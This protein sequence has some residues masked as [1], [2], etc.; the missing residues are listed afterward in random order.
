MVAAALL[1]VGVSKAPQ[2]KAANLYWD[3]D[4]TAAG[5]NISN[6]TGLGGAGTWDTSELEWF[7]G[8]DNVAWS[9]SALDVAYF[10]GTAGTVTLG[11]PITVGGLVFTG[12]DYTLTGG[13]L[14]LAAATG[15]PEIAVTNGNVATLASV[16]AGTSGL[17]KTGEGTLRL[18]QAAN[19]YAGTTTI[20]GGLLIISDASQ[21]GTDASAIVVTA[22][23]NTPSNTALIGFAGG[24][25]VLDGLGAS[26]DLARPLNLE[27]RGPI[28]N[29]GAALFS[30]GNNTL[31]GL[32]TASVSSQ[33]PATFR[34]TRLTSSNGVLTLSGGLVVQGT[35]GTTFT[36]LGG[37]NQGGVANY[38]LTG[39]LTGTGTLQKTGGGTLNLSPSD[40]SGF[41]GRVR[42]SGSAANGQSS[43][44]VTSAAAFGTANGGTT[45]ATIDIDG[46]TLEA[47]TDTTINFAKNVY[48]RA[49][50]RFFV[51]NAI[52]G[53][54]VN[55]GVA[56]GNFSFEDNQ[57][58]TFASRNGFGA[59]FTTAPVNGGDANNTFNNDQAGLLAFSGNFWSNTDSGAARTFTFGGNGN[60][61]IDGN[62]IASGG[63]SFDHALS[64]TGSGLLTITGT[65]TTLD[66]AVS[67]QGGLAITDFRS[68]N[69]NTSAVNL[70]SGGTAGALIIGTGVTPTAGGLTTS[71]PINLSSSTGGVSIYANQAGSNP[72][73]FNGEFSTTAGGAT[74][75]KTLTLGGTNTA[76]NVI[77]GTLEN[78]ASATTGTL[79]LSKIGAGT[80]VL[81]GVN[82][83]SGGTT[84]TDGVLKLRANAATSTILP[85]AHAITFNANN[86]FAGGT[87]E[88]VGQASVNN[89]QS[90]GALTP[91]QGANTI[92]VTP[93]AGGNASLT[94]ASLGTIGDGATV[95]IVGSNGSSSVVTL[96]GVATG[97]VAPHFHFS[98]AHFAYSASAVLR[99]PV[100]G[101][102][103][104]FVTAPAAT[105]LPAGQSHFDVTGDITAQ[106]SQT[107]GTL[108]LA[109]ARTVTLASGATLTVRTG[110]A[111]TDGGLLATGGASVITGGTGISTG[112]SGA[113]IVRVNE[114][115]DSLTLAS[116]L[117]NGTTGGLT[118]S[119]AGTL[120]L[121]G[122]NAQTGTISINQGTI[123]LSGSGRLGRP[124]PPS[125]S[126]KGRCWT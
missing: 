99:A 107:V 52:G 32:V 97:L 67:V 70:G 101:T 40:A 93:G 31:S 8:T 83:F 48:G 36:T 27:G 113:L 65:G 59:S 88:L 126:G 81:A 4:A 55:G 112:G 3:S 125:P 79:A 25:L 104:G 105:A 106:A 114:L 82:T 46:G 43:V 23:N 1:G 19:T 42:I 85:S 90:L 38:N 61:L 89:V 94:F 49:G 120:I 63:A 124:T 96:T 50:S 64:K 30:V 20:A 102:D 74:E 37:V 56:Y 84:I 69:N 10:T 108:R 5:N 116:V 24:S 117:T 87:L 29:N 76:D 7:N 34:N 54:A 41:S 121:S 21:L 62:V 110:A 53:F 92:R 86:V 39:A 15:A 60:T 77:T 115:T 68:L 44:R 12:A 51:S 111:N 72:V 78:H 95:N 122:N 73:I 66:G 45:N 18:T 26:I 6:G 28:G 11:G 75:S 103:S 119:G 9:N 14:T 109:G 80:W 17:T 100:Y 13:T 47:Y 91:T 118:K 71:K 2:A 33:T 35:A 58:F 123:Q 16:I 98:G 57:T 22:G